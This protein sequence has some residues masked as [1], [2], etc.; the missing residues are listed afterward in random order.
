MAP[1]APRARLGTS[2][3]E[4]LPHQIEDQSPHGGWHL[5]GKAELGDD[6]IGSL[7]EAEVKERTALTFRGDELAQPL[8]EP[9]VLRVGGRGSAILDLAA[10][11]PA[12]DSLP[13]LHA[14]NELVALQRAHERYL[15]L[16][17]AVPPGLPS[18]SPEVAS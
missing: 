4:R 13:G 9:G 7:L 14:S 18:V 6:A 17:H 12:Y 15:G 1:I 8:Y 5:F 3:L 11:C 16:V 10:G 2:G